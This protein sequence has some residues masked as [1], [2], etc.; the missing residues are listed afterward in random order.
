MKVDALKK[1][2]KLAIQ[3]QEKMNRRRMKKIQHEKKE[4]TYLVLDGVWREKRKEQIWICLYW[5]IKQP[6]RSI[7]T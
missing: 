5:E 1:E 3:V 6:S 4:E 7:F 2:V